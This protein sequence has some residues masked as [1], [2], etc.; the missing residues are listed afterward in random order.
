MYIIKAD[1]KLLYSPELTDDGYKL[2]SPRMHL[3][4]GAAGYLEFTMPPCNALYDDVLKMKSIITVEQDGEV[5]FRGRISEESVDTYKQ[6]RVYC[7]GD[8]A[9]LLDSLQ[10]PASFTGTQLDLFSQL[11]A[12][13]NAQMEAEKW[14][15]L[16][17]VSGLDTE[18]V[19]SFDVPSYMDTM[20]MIQTYLIDLSGGYIQTRTEGGVTYID[21]VDGFVDECSQKIEFGVNLLD[22]ESQINAEELCT[23][24]VPLGT[25]LEDGTSLTIASVNDGKV[26]IENPEAIARYGRVYKTYT[27]ENVTDPAELMEMGMEYMSGAGLPETLSITALDMHLVDADVE[28]IRKGS[29]VHL[30]SK[31][32]GIDKK[33]VC[34]SIDADLENAEQTV[35]VLGLPKQRLKTLAEKVEE[36]AAG[37]DDVIFDFEDIYIDLDDTMGEVNRVSDKVDDH[38]KWLTETD[39]SLDIAIEH[40]DLIGHRVN[41]VEV[42]V[43]AAE[44]AITMKANQYSVDVLEERMSGAEVRIDGAEAE[45]DMKAAQ[46]VVDAL[47][48]RMSGA[49]ARIDG[50]EAE[51]TLKA[52]KSTVD[53]MGERLST[54]E[55]RIDGAESKITAK[56]DLILLD[57]YVKAS[58][59]EAEILTVLEYAWA[60]DLD[61]QS[62]VAGS[63]NTNYLSADSIS[64]DSL[65]VGGQSVV[66]SSHT[67]SITVGS[68]GSISI[69]E[70]SSSGGSFNIADT[71]FYKDGVSAAKN[72]VTLTSSGWQGGVTTVSASNGKSLNVSL[73]SFSVSGGDSFSG[74]KTTVY[75]YTGSVSG[76]LASKTVDASGVYSSGYSAGNTAGFNSGYSNGYTAGQASIDTGAYYDEGYEI[77]YSKG[78]ASVDTTSYYNSGWN[79][80]RDACSLVTVYT[81]SE[82]S[83]GTLYMKVGDYYSSVGSSWVKVSRMYGVYTIPSAK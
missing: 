69:G 70:V 68:D 29:M 19:F 54:A 2:I 55:L 6:R 65:S 50:A 46:S 62:L 52:A 83:P 75:F 32:H 64:T 23:V 81:I 10:G 28:K 82:N 5:V 73:P 37:L 21:Y 58:D 39:T 12:S 34:A 3:E 38:H 56:A 77:G 22:F 49:E 79:A 40:L 57:G 53:E 74:N 8:L 24:L 61:V 45:I 67:H 20:N 42:D 4:I 47:G 33:I 63:V 48:S 44:A 11:I 18:E 59:L 17:D 71:S 35:F 15:M 36:A 9:F 41:Q 31:P 43:D 60:N 1:G 51:I 7:E 26:Y 16:G 66:T 80:C 76:Y 30:L 14:F 25:T 72:S 27:W 78:V 13:H